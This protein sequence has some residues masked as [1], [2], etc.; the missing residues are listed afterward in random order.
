MSRYFKALIL[1]SIIFALFIFAFILF[2]KSS[3]ISKKSVTIVK[4]RSIKEYKQI[5]KVIDKSSVNGAL[6]NKKMLK[7]KKKKVIQK[8]LPKKMVVKKKI[9]KKR[10]HKKSIVKKVIRKRVTKSKIATKRKR[11]S[12]KIVKKI[13]K[14]GLSKQT[15][16]VSKKSIQ[17]KS[18]NQEIAK[19]NFLATLRSKI[20]SHIIYPMSARAK[21]IEGKVV[22]NFDIDRFGE[23]KN[24]KF[25][26]AKRVFRKSVKDAFRV[27]F[28]IKI[29]NNL[30]NIS[31]YRDINFPI[32]FKID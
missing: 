11:L 21:H 5:K 4:I 16:R 23:L 30:E 19:S 25:V 26:R 24:F 12:K 8:V 17:K 9:L 3:K 13:S 1:T 29:P 14:R 22:V 15:T 28:P 2:I 32:N 20:R 6:S 27:V 10:Y 31:R 18:F 7:D